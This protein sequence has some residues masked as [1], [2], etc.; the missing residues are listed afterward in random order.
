MSTLTGTAAGTG[1]IPAG[2]IVGIGVV[3]VG[4]AAGIG[5]V[6][7]GVVLALGLGDVVLGG[8]VLIAAPRTGR[9]GQSH[10]AGQTDGQTSSEIFFP[11]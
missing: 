8:G 9:Q 10:D 1:I 6:P 3:S 11:Q 7:V 4:M 5:V 2:T